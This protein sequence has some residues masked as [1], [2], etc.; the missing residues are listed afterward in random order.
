MHEGELSDEICLYISADD[1]N[2]LVSVPGIS[3][4]DIFFKEEPSL[5]SVL[6]QFGYKE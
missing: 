4:S 6:K 5:R 2:R 1:F 3:E